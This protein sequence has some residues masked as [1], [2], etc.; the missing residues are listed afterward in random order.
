MRIHPFRALRPPVALAADVASPPYDVVD[1]AQARVLAEGNENSFLHI[2]RPEIDLPE[3][4]EL[5]DDSVYEQAK[6]NFDAFVERGS[7]VRD[8]EPSVFLYEVTMGGHSQ[9]GLVATCHVEDYEKDLIKKHEKTLQAKEDDRTRHVDTLNAQAGPIFLTYRADA[10]MDEL[11]DQAKQ[12]D[13]VYSFVAPDGVQHRVW[14]MIDAEPFQQAFENVP[15]TY[16]ADGHHRSASAA[17]VARMRADANPAHDGTEPYNWFLTV[18]FPDDQL[19][20]MAYNR[21]VQDLNGLDLDSFLQRVGER[22]DVQASGVSKP[23][24]ATDISMYLAGTWYTLSWTPTGDEDPVTGLDVSVLQQSL[25]API[26]G[27]DDPRTSTRIKF[28]GGIHGAEGLQREVDGRGDGVAFALYPTS[29][30]QLMAIADADQIM[31]PKSTWFEPK[32]RSG[33][34][35][36]IME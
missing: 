34:F 21:I 14:R 35:I 17:R 2:V 9:T 10:S 5:Y 3:G 20:I 12:Q 8:E 7:L 25:L 22:F 15:V 18:L 28:M 4:T 31:P 24:C 33:L 23:A 36:N 1:T 29:V 6:K 30:D 11:V 27:I 26:L 32:L 19:R 16:V 13:P